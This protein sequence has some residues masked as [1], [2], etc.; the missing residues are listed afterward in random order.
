MTA[1]EAPGRELAE[2]TDDELARTVV[3]EMLTV[4]GSLASRDAAGGTA[5]VRV[6]AQIAALRR[7]IHA[8]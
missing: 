1:A 6:A 7:T 8:D 5:P 4:R 2:L 3:R